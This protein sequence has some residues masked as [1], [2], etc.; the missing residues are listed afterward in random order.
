MVED[1]GESDRALADL[2][3][4][5]EQLARD[6]RAAGDIPAILAPPYFSARR[7]ANGWPP[8]PPCLGHTA[9]QSS[10]GPGNGNGTMPGAAGW[11]FSAG[12]RFGGQVRAILTEV[13]EPAPRETVVSW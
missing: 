10:G 1:A 4:Q 2:E 8:G 12:P 9:W 13:E 7:C 5:A 6:L 3:G 11:H